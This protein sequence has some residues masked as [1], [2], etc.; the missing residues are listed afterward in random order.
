[1]A[2]EGSASALFS[3]RNNHD[4]YLYVRVNTSDATGLTFAWELQARRLSGS[5]SFDLGS[6]RWDVI[7][8]GQGFSG[9][10]TPDFRSTSVISI[11][12]G[13]TTKKTYEVVGSAV[14]FEAG[15]V[16]GLFGT[17]S[18]SGSFKPPAKPADPDTV[19]TGIQVPL[20]LSATA[21]RIDFRIYAPTN[22]GGDDVIDYLLQ[23]SESSGFGTIVASKTSPPTTGSA[24]PKYLDGLDPSTAHWIRYRA[25]N[26][27]GS[28][29]WSPSLKATTKGG[30]TV[31]DGTT[32]KAAEV[33]V[34]DGTAWNATD[35]SVSNGT[36][37]EA[38][39]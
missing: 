27:V 19:P 37:W 20:F 38:A 16:A 8:E 29:A 39:G 11:A 5:V 9:N 26:S 24:N 6:Y 34:S 17:A 35:I 22:D 25:R 15:T 18:P 7:V 10:W 30:V 14:T 33:F 31:S 2:T 1:M 32:W 4:L 21:S 3:G 28:S 12:T 13:T 36:A 23:A